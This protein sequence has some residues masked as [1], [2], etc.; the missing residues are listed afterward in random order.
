MNECPVFN[1]ASIL[2]KKWTIVL[3]HEITF[4]GDKGF[5]FL[6]KRMRKISPKVL[7][8][9]LEELEKLRIIEREVISHS[10]PL[11]TKYVLTEKGEEL[12]RIIADIKV[13]NMKYSDI[14]LECN[15][16]ECVKC[17]LY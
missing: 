4:N 13:W 5:N 15:N 10:K 12:Q 3:I 2:G 11:R 7:S 14:R 1:V 16:K 17:S 6:F 9:R 8:R